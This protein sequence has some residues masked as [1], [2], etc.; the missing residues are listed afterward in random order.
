M[1]HA[2]IQKRCVTIFSQSVIKKS[3]VRG[4]RDQGTLREFW[5]DTGPITGSKRGKSGVAAAVWR[6]VIRRMR[7][8]ERRAKDNVT[9]GGGR[10]DKYSGCYGICICFFRRLPRQ[11]I[12]RNLC[13]GASSS[14]HRDDAFLSVVLR[15]MAGPGR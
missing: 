9:R 13:V 14:H 15:M 10:E 3:R 7:E 8:V 1:R 4:R 12:R 2:A 11:L 6:V 5:T